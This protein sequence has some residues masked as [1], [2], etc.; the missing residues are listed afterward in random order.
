MSTAATYSR[1]IT[2]D[3]QN[4]LPYL[5]FNPFSQKVIQILGMIPT[6][7][8]FSIIVIGLLKTFG[9]IYKNKGFTKSLNFIFWISLLAPYFIYD[10][11]LF[12]PRHVLISL[13][14]FSINFDEIFFKNDHKNVGKDR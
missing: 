9:S 5:I 1:N 14:I 3:I 2:F 12:Y 13:V 4:N 8:A 11:V 6:V 7:I 10:P